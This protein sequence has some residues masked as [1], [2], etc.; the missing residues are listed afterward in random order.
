MDQQKKILVNEE[1][2]KKSKQW[3]NFIRAK[4]GFRNHWYPVL[5]ADE[6]KEGEPV[7]TTLCGENLLLNRVDGDVFAIKDRC[8]HR[9]V[10]LSKKVEC[11]T[12]DTITCWYHAWTYQ[13]KDG[14]LCDIMTDPG[15]K[16]IGKHSLKTYQVQ[17]AKGLVFIFLGDIE[18]TPLIDDVPPGFLDEGRAIRGMRREVASNWRVAAENGFDSTHV[19]IHKDSKLIKGNE[20]V[21]PLGFAPPVDG[22]EG[23]LWEV[24]NNASGPKGVYDNIGQHAMPV[25]E[26]KI[27]GETVLRPVL[28]GD[29]RIA[30]QISIWMPGA[31]KVDP[32]PDPTLVQ[33]EWYVPKDENTHWYIQTLGREV[34]NA[35][36]EEQFNTEFDEKWKDLGLHGFNDDD[37]WAREAMEKFYKDDWGWIKEQLFESDGNIIAW[38]KLASEANRGIQTLDDL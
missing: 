13:W 2:V 18:P 5:F 14:L 4:L 32:F 17:E 26:G 16:M 38:R 23:A 34:A 21:I 24:V 29:K 20:T 28:G 1:V 27:H 7:K 37:I 9:G 6:V 35:A 22:D 33:F 3:P 15:S 19:F 10:E 36:E 8:L 30:Q 25:M 12:K 31:L 11:Y